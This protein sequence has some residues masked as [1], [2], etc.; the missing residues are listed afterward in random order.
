MKKAII[1][2]LAIIVYYVILNSLEIN[3]TRIPEFMV[4]VLYVFL[5]IV[6]VPLGIYFIF[7]TMVFK[8]ASKNKQEEKQMA[9]MKCKEC[10]NEVSAKA[11]S[12]PKCGAKIKV[13]SIGFGLIL[14]LFLIGL[15]L[16][17]FVNN[18]NSPSS[19]PSKPIASDVSLNMPLIKQAIPIKKKHPSWPNETCNTIAEKKISIGM[20]ADQVRASWG[21]PY[22]INSSMG[23]G[24]EHEQWVV[25]GIFQ[26]GEL[27]FGMGGP[28]WEHERENRLNSSY[29]YFENGILTSI[30]QSE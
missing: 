14:V 9:L 8:D 16:H 20:T 4:A 3:V 25:H 2:I 5:P 22:R 19:T 27:L 10:G 18:S 1:T 24:W 7:G 23:A 29:L 15:F 6:F 13:K 30:Q 17:F 12:C 21:K 28:E 26:G 11:D